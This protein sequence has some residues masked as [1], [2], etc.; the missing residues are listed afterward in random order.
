MSLFRPLSLSENF[1]KLAQKIDFNNAGEEG[2]DHIHAGTLDQP[3]L[4]TQDLDGGVKSEGASG[5]A[6]KEMVTFQPSLWPWDSI[7]SS[8]K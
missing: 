3:D 1:T 2:D 7:R 6:K 5:D 8:L 4:L